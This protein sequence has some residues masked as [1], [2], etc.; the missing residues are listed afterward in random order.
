MRE[1]FDRKKLKRLAKK[2]GIVRMSVFGSHARGE[3]RKGSDLDLLVKFKSTRKLSLFGFAGVQIDFED[4]LHIP[5]DLVMEGT[6]YP[7]IKPYVEKEA[8]RVV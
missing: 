5:V 7:R 1:Q 8:I 4:Q 3:A 2:H 6:L